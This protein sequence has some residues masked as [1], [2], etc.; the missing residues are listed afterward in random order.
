M[1][2]MKYPE[3]LEDIIEA[4]R[5]LPGVGRRT[6]ERMALAM[7][8][9]RSDKLET[10]GELLQHLPQTVTFCPECG[11]LAQHGEKC[12]ICQSPSRNSELLCV[13]EEFSQ[14]VSIENSA[15]FKGVY[16]V[17]GGKISPLD[18]RGAEDLRLD[19]LMRRIGRGQ[20]EE[21]ILAMSPDVEGQATAIYIADLLQDKGL[22]ISRLARGL[23]AGA[24]LSYADAATIGAALE[25]RTQ[26]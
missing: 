21:I 22:K 17:L 13:V 9:W 4:L 25:G 1:S 3:T 26:I 11:N 8:K 6:A 5:R 12:L 24:D 2:G 15:S 23:P 14:V 19:I 20:I 10:L 16:H 18:N 7:L